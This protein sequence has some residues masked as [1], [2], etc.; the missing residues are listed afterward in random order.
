MG[1]SGCYI[2]SACLEHKTT[3]SNIKINRCHTTIMSYQ[4]HPVPFFS[5]PPL[6]PL[7]AAAGAAE[8]A[9]PAAPVPCGVPPLTGCV[10][11][12]GTEAG[13]EVGSFQKSG[14]VN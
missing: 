9:L 3:T 8:R 4:S 1:L 13:Q 14:T 5:L 12:P 6:S 2:A 10:H 11:S 7:G